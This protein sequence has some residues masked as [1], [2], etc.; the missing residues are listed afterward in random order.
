MVAKAITAVNKASHC[1]SCASFHVA[2]T[3]P[4]SGLS[5]ANKTMSPERSKEGR[6]SSR[7]RAT[8]SIM[9]HSGA[10]ARCPSVT[11]GGQLS[12]FQEQG[13]GR[14]SAVLI[15]EYFLF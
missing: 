15:K 1:V 3:R 5:A 8:Q 14:Q 7:N 10:L 6:K 4:A 2:G 11:Y 12:H 9:T 13:H